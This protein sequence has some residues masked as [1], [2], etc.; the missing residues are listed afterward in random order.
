MTFHPGC[1]ALGLA[2]LSSAPAFATDFATDHAT[3]F[4]LKA[5][6]A[7]AA[8]LAEDDATMRLAADLVRRDLQAVGGA[9]AA[10]A[11]RLADCREV[12]VVIGRH[13]SPLLRE[14]AR[15]E[16]LDFAALAGQWERYQR[17]GIDSRARPGTRLLVIAGSDARGAVFGA[18][19]LT[20]EIGVS[21]WEWWADV[22]PRTADRI[23]VRG[24]K[25]LSDAP[26]VRYRGIFLNDEDW[27]LQPWAAQ[28]FDPAR[29]IG[30]ATYA[31][32][33]ELLW[34]LKANLLWPAM[35]DST[36]PFYQVPGNAQAA[37]DYAIIV[38]TSH[39][40]PMMRNNVR[41]WNKGDGDFN[42]FTNRAAIARYWKTRVDETTGAEAFYTMGIRGVHDSAM[43]GADTIDEARAGVTDAIAL[44]RR[45][46]ADAWRKPLPRI[47]QA[48]TVYKEMLDI[49]NSGLRVPDDITLVWP[50][51]NYGYLHQLSTP[52]EAARSGG[53]GLYY[54]ISYWGRPH[55]YLWLA[56]TPPGLL[57]DQLQRAVATRTDRLWVLNVGDIKPA[58]YLTQY[59]LDAAFDKRQLDRPAAGHMGEWFAQQFG[60]AQAPAIA[61][62][63][64]EFYALAW[65]RKPEY[66]GFSQTEPTTPTR[67]ADY[68]QSGGEE[69]E[70][71]LARYEALALRAQAIGAALPADRKDA[72]FQLVLYPV[73][74][75]ANLNA[76]ILKL[77]LAAQYARMGRPSAQ[78]Y[79]SA[80]KAAQAAIAA[81]TAHYN[82]QAGGKWRGMMD[83]APRRLPVFAEPVFPAYGAPSRSDC[84]L[85]F[86]SPL[87]AQ[88]GAL[89]FTRGVPE[90]K[91]LTVIQYA[92]APLRWSAGKVPAGLRLSHDGGTLDAA[93]GYEQRIAVAYDGKGD[94]NG[95]Q[96]GCGG[97]RLTARV[98]VAPGAAIATEHERIITLPATLAS[99]PGWTPVEIGSFG[100]AQRAD[101]ALPSRDDP[102]GAPA[103]D[104]P[105]HSHTKAGARL[106]IVA[107]P[108]H[109]LTS[110]SKLRIAVSLDGEA[111]VT[112][113]FGT[114]GRSD[115]WKRNVLSNSAVRTLALPALAPGAHRLRVQALDPGFVLDRIEVVFDGAP[116]FYGAPPI[117]APPAAAAR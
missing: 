113:D 50:D 37:K 106:R 77:D 45:L 5:G 103:L 96:I 61:D 66:M 13:D 34:R 7:V 97:Q 71:R 87:S 39:A 59:F 38:G 27:G 67:Q 101:L 12:C 22:K 55:D 68:L 20:R 85:A 86:P 32:I 9:P 26:S 36:K 112:L 76:R 82:A 2:L 28:T 46:L 11:A 89:W 8:V 49:Y 69:A 21:A 29:D 58:E 104:Y 110:A 100:M 4:D 31:R 6:R 78:H 15:T 24:A 53:T 43:E 48:L 54:H 35:H 92:A 105:F 90:T 63:M 18:V 25:I 40:E 109:A 33:F 60:A 52:K 107:V 14:I 30:P 88:G 98:Q 81:D 83:A 93:N 94:T 56:T 57:R 114:V 41:E 108:V 117:P 84:G 102:A 64:R 111:P 73:R 51:D 70:Q 44:Q 47:P 115:E 95:L 1:L 10:R 79:A 42:F 91:T 74:A 17:V 65:E 116:Q 16:G 75:S 80:A 19:D 99:A 72:F 3:G 23:A 62:I